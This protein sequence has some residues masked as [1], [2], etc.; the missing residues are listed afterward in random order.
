LKCPGLLSFLS[1]SL[2]KK[3]FF[4]INYLQ[5]G[6]IA[7]ATEYFYIETSEQIIGEIKNIKYKQFESPFH[8]RFASFRETGELTISEVT[9][10]IRVSK[11][12]FFH[13]RFLHK[14]KNPI[15]RVLGIAL[16]GC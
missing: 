1:K 2:E 13:L 11:F 10:I 6:R 8:T 15:C 4:K 14:I 5:N 3:T 12:S 16:Q 7:A 9:R